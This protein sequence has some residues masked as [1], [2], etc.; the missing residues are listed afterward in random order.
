MVWETEKCDLHFYEI[1]Q[2]K[3]SSLISGNKKSNNAALKIFDDA[4]KYINIR[5]K[6]LRIKENAI[7]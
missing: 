5:L 3:K 6:Q 7:K 2:F 1:T 4:D